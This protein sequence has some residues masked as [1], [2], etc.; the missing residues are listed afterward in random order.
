MFV[1]NSSGQFKMRYRFSQESHK[2]CRSSKKEKVFEILSV[3]FIYGLFYGPLIGVLIVVL[4]LP[5]RQ[6][7]LLRIRWYDKATKILEDVKPLAFKEFENDPNTNPVIKGPIL[8]VRVD[9]QF[10]KEQEEY[11]IYSNIR[12]RPRNIRRS[13]FNKIAHM[14]IE[15]SELTV[16][17]QIEV[18]TEP[19]KFIRSSGT[20]KNFQ[21]YP[22]TK[23]RTK[24]ELR[25]VYWPQKEIGY[26]TY[27][28]SH[29]T[30]SSDECWPEDDTSALERWLYSLPIT[31]HLH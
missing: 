6:E 5:Y 1:K 30:E 19:V 15:D 12:L 22:I 24:Y 21:S 25:L 16:V 26:S 17:F 4:Y 20:G 8:H 23:F 28:W 14:N 18:D 7:E 27:R 2:E 10:Y 31:E 9:G 13:I 11:H 29:P 3:V